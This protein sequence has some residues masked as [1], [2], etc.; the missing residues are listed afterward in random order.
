[1]NQ[2]TRFFAV[3]FI[4]IPFLS[5]AQQDDIFGMLDSI[6]KPETEYA[7]ATF[8]SSRIVTGQSVE[9]MKEGQLEFRIEHRFGTL[10]SG[11]YNFYGLDGGT[12]FL[13]T[14]Y[15]VTDWMMIGLG[16]ASLEKD[17]NGFIKLNIYRQSKGKRNFPFTITY[18]G[19]TTV[20]SLKD[21]PAVKNY[22]SNRLGYVN[23]FLIARKI[24]NS[25]SL[26]LSPI[27][28]H[29]NLV[30]TA[31]DQNDLFAC[32]VGGRYKLS[33]RIAITGEYYYVF[34][35]KLNSTTF[36]N[37]LSVGIDIETGGHVF[38]FML[39]NSIGMLEN[40]YIAEN[41]GRW[42]KGDIHLGFN[43]SRSFTLYGKK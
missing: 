6:S 18:Y 39:T 10:N 21:D 34:R 22:F 9:Q 27:H 17:F 26:Q 5:I 15:G 16:R 32:G 36:Y 30:P 8:K 2:L 7:T 20:S 41:T 23:Q 31:F 4:T 12:I 14:E 43:I 11:F 19:A 29:R 24:T 40:Q 1:M 25:L 42:T 35:S 33:K 38:S 28:I 37:P 3:I 13:S